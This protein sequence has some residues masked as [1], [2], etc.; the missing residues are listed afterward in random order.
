MLGLGAIDGL[1]PKVPSLDG[2]AVSGP[3]AV[4]DAVGGLEHAA[5]VTARAAMISRRTFVPVAFPSRYTASAE[6]ETRVG[7][8]DLE[9]LDDEALGTNQVCRGAVQ[10]HQIL[11]RL[12]V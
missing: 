4:G 10:R 6:P 3:A 8:E 2:G 1:A 9:T 12:G 5:S 11:T 7:P